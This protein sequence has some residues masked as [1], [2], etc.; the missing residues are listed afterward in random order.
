[1]SGQPHY[2]DTGDDTE[3]ERE[4]LPGRRWRGRI[5]VIAIVVAVLLVVLVLHLTGAVGAGTNG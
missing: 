5:A 1:M 3:A 4:P 2:P